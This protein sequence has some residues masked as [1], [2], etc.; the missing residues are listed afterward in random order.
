MIILDNS[1]EDVSEALT[2]SIEH[3]EECRDAKYACYT[4]FV[5]TLHGDRL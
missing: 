1:L 5:K 3:P 4:R 2:W